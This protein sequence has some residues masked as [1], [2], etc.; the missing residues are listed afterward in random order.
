M[1]TMVIARRC[2]DYHTVHV[3]VLVSKTALSKQ[4]WNWTHPQAFLAVCLLP[5]KR[6]SFSDLYCISFVVSSSIPVE[7]DIFRPVNLRA[8]IHYFTHI[9][10]RTIHD[11]QMCLVNISDNV[12]VDMSSCTTCGSHAHACKLVTV[13]TVSI[14]DSPINNGHMIYDISRRVVD[15]INLIETWQ[16]LGSPS[17]CIKYHYS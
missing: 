9:I 7:W 14:T 12:V 17:S 10:C 1:W 11:R 8:M 16:C 2:I 4:T 5:V 15:K 3:L 13:V 6:W